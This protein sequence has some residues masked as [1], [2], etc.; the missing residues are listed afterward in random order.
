M[1]TLGLALALFGLNSSWIPG[2]GWIGVVLCLAGC[3]LGLRSVSDRESRLL[4]TV[5]G[6]CA[7]V[8]GG[9]GFLF[10]LGVQVKHGAPAM[11]G[12]LLPIPWWQAAV[13]AA[14]GALVAFGALLLARFK[15]RGVGLALAIAALVAMQLLGV[16]A[17]VH[18]DREMER[19]GSVV[20]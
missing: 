5:L 6:T 17:L 14:G 8:F 1:H 16:S 7:A 2:W 4:A 18:A 19:T 13:G 15:A 3:L 9:L 12:L 10:G 11:D 20:E